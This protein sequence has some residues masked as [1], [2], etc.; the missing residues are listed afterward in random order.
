MLMVLMWVGLSNAPNND[1]PTR[2][3]R[4]GSMAIAGSADRFF[5][6]RDR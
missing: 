6:W 3:L 1:I 5:K 2:T 4:I